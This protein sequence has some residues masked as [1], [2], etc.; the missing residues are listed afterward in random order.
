MKMKN[1]LNMILLWEKYTEKIDG[2]MA[3]VMALD[4]VIRLGNINAASV[5]DERGSMFFLNTNRLYSHL[6]CSCYCFF[7]PFRIY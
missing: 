1:G 4:R 5:Y 3:T 6:M 7:A 2:A